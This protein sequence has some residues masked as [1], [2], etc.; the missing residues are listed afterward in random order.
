MMDGGDGTGTSAAVEGHHGRWVRV[1]T[2]RRWLVRVPGTRM[3]SS[4]DGDGGSPRARDRALEAA[5]KAAARR[6]VRKH[7]LF[8]DDDR[9]VLTEG[10]WR[11]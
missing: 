2:S 8:R 10:W 7:D 3:A 6:G 9:R 4:D 1:D 11:R 5:E